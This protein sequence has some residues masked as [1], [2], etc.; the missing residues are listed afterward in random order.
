M[1]K[2]QNWHNIIKSWQES[3]EKHT[4]WCKKKGH[5]YINIQVL[6]VSLKKLK[7]NKRTISRIGNKET[8]RNNKSII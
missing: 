4:I 7:N 8:K 6:E 3:D 2:T 1:D 5:K